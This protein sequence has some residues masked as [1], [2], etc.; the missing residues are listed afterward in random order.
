M[1]KEHKQQY[2]VVIIGGG[3]AG[4]AAALY[5][6]RS[7]FSVLVL[8]KLSP[9]GQ[10][11]TTGQVDNYPGFDEGI[12][13]FELAEKMQRGA[14]RFGA[15]TAFSEVLSLDLKAQPKRIQT[16]D[17]EILARSVIIATGASPRELGLA[18][19]SQLR[20]RGVAYC[21]TCDGM[22]YKDKTVIV[23][24]GGN[25]AV[26]DALFLSK[27]CKK[28]YLVHR[29]N[30]LRASKVYL[31]ALEDSGVEFLWNSRITE[32][33]HDKRV[34]G[35]MIEEL[36]SGKIAQVAC[37]GIFVAI[38]RVPDTELFKDQ[39]DM[40]STGYLIA[41]ESTKTNIPGVY[42]VG[43]VRTKPLRQIVTAA[44]DGA[45]ASHFIEEFLAE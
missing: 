19:E 12:D 1:T 31:K 35:A 27:I 23:S 33:L 15:E 40:D 39:V 25:T 29:R 42:A 38:G 30:Q 18:G 45:V 5:C 37:D 41:D 21:A 16:T 9:G 10:M 20:G 43:D 44:A 11:A 7:S 32:I 34:T 14:E 26:A 24:G 17:G 13:G 4:Y 2:D 22:M 28:V 8:E 6:A 36:T 3:P